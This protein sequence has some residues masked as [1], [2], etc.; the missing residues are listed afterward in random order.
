MTTRLVLFYCHLF[1][2]AARP[3]D[4]AS[5]RGEGLPVHA[6]VRDIFPNY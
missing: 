6:N 1:K 2:L 4:I 5:D 3:N